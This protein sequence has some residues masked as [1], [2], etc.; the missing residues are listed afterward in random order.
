M[1]ETSSTEQLS[2]V[3]E[4][5]LRKAVVFLYSKVVFILAFMAAG[6]MLSLLAL[7]VVKESNVTTSNQIRDLMV[8]AISG[9]F[10][11]W[12]LLVNA[13]AVTWFTKVLKMANPDQLTPETQDQMVGVFQN[14]LPDIRNIKKY[15]NMNF[16]MMVIPA[17]FCV[18]GFLLSHFGGV[19]LKK[20]MW[21][22]VII[23]AFYAAANIVLYDA[24]RTRNIRLKKWWDSI[25]PKEEVEEVAGLVPV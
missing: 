17:F 12:Q 9:A 22:G 19:D 25:E 13:S 4:T 2:S 8:T 1:S 11:I 24:I 3:F 15:L 10:V 20:F 5:A 16:G 14:A 6:T 23:V 18:A 7:K 21:L